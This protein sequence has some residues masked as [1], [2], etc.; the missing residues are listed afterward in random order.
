MPIVKNVDE[1]QFL[2]VDLDI[3]SRSSLEPI[4]LAMGRTVH[5][6]Y[7]GRE[8]GLYK[9]YLELHR[10]LSAAACIRGFCAL[11]RKLPQA[12]RK[13]WDTATIREFNVGIQAQMKPITFEI[14]VGEEAVRQAAD[15][16]ARI[17]VTIYSPAMKAASQES[18]LSSTKERS[19]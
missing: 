14:T 11:I 3:R 15:L 1:T 5:V 4:A 7:V 18:L 2:N 19:C 12:E 13:L 8:R 10:H 16:D 9:A 6:L 17:G